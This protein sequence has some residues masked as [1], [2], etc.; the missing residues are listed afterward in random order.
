MPSWMSVLVQSVLMLRGLYILTVERWVVLVVMCIRPSLVYCLCPI[1][2][3]INCKGKVAALNL[4]INY[5]G[6]V[7]ALNLII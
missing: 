6:K 4:I 2:A 7:A 5:T 1:T 3:C